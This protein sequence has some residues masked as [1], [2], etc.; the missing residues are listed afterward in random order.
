ELDMKELN[1]KTSKSN[2]QSTLLKYSDLKRELKFSSEIA[3][4]NV[5]LSKTSKDDLLIKSLID[6]T[7]YNILKEVG[8]S[9]NTSLPFA[10]IGSV[11][12][13]IIDLQVD[14]FDIMKIQ[15]GQNCYITMDSKK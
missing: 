4:K 10:T 12:S 15:I 5:S 2:Y 6:G 1:Y 11:D 8:E 13:F 7:V 9:I 14:E 3:N